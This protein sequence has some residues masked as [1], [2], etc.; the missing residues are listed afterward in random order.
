M[1]LGHR[2]PQA[3]SQALDAA[4]PRWSQLAQRIATAIFVYSFSADETTRGDTLPYVK[5]AVLRNDT[6]PAL[7]TECY[8]ASPTPSGT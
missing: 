2:G 4:N 7:V 8:I 3:T 1:I 6:I 5:L